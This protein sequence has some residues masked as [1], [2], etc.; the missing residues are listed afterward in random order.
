MPVVGGPARS[1]PRRRRDLVLQRLHRRRG[2][3][4]APPPRDPDLVQEQARR[5]RLGD[6]RRA[7]RDQRR[8]ATASMTLDLRQPS[9]RRGPGRDRRA[10]GDPRSRR[11]TAG[12][13]LG[14]TAS[15]TTPRTS[16]AFVP[17]GGYAEPRRLPRAPRAR[18]RSA[19][20]RARRR[21]A[22]ST[23]ATLNRRADRLAN[24]LAGTRRGPGRPGCRAS[25]RT[26]TA[27]SSASSRARRPGSCSRRSTAT[28]S[29]DEIEHV[30]RDSGAGVY[31]DGVEGYDELVEG[32]SEAPHESAG[33]DD[34]P[35]LLMYTS[36]T[37]GR[38][39]G[40]VLSHRQRP[41]HLVQP[42]PR[43]GADA[44]RDRALVVAP[45]HH[46][47]GLVVLGLPCLH[48][49]GAVRTGVPDPR[50]VV[51]TVAR[52]GATAI[53]LSPHLW[54]QVAELDDLETHDLSSV[55]LCASGGDP[56]PTRGARAA[57]R[58]LRRRLHRCL[59]TD[60]GGVRVDASA[61]RG[62]PPEGRARQGLP[63][64]HNR[65]RVLAPDGSEARPARRASSCR[66]GRP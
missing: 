25:C 66:R 2:R 55:R 62:H 5:D 46:V 12:R 9:G 7:A 16:R 3:Q 63:C 53:F 49:G 10:R 33:R 51:E 64:T 15:A 48:V 22:S 35:L 8:S 52:D 32:A 23:Y 34:D 37:T 39:K 60:R 50:A 4:G 20:G 29:A 40:V 6:Q 42:D 47:G 54:R 38:P 59:R 65:L 44:P 27:T 1:P 28:S 11:G 41:L 30:L 26:G 17:V 24:A 56:V 19:G 57:A 18:A 21:R 36:G 43:L 45:F 13:G 61:A 14:R 58:R 31:I